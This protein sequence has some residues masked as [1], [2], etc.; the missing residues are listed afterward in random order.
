M[1]QMEADTLKLEEE[2][3]SA[4]EQMEKEDRDFE[5]FEKQVQQSRSRGLF[6]K[7]LYSKPVS[8]SS[9]GS[10]ERET[11]K[12]LQETVSTSRKK[13]AGSKTRRVLYRVLLFLVSLVLVDLALVEE[14][15]WPKLALYSIL[16][17]ALIAQLV[18]EKT[19]TSEKK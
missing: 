7:S 17:L 4:R 3:A 8:T 6:F 1:E 19:L 11:I 5:E 9:L 13:A 14:K 15:D 18:Y 12:E 2:L 10:K 16:C